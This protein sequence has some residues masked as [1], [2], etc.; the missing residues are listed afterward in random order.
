MAVYQRD[1]GEWRVDVWWNGEVVWTTHAPTKTEGQ[2]IHDQAKVD[3]RAG[4]DPWLR[5]EV[6]P[7]REA[8]TV[9]DWIETWREGRGLKPR[10]EANQKSLIDNHIV[11]SIG[12]EPLESL[13]R[14][15]V[16]R[17]VK[18]LEADLMPR[19][20][21]TVYSILAEALAD[22]ADDP[23]TKLKVSPAH[24]IR[25]PKPDPTG[26]DVLTP[27]QVAILIR[28]A[29]DRGFIIEDLAFTGMRAG[30]YTGRRRHDLTIRKTIEIAGRPDSRRVVARAAADGETAKRPVRGKRGRTKAPA[31]KTPAGARSIV[32]C[33]EHAAAWSARLVTHDVDALAVVQSSIMSVRRGRP[34][35]VAYWMVQEVV[36]EAR[37][38]AIEAGEDIPDGVTA[39]WFRVTHRTWLEEAHV[40]EI[41]IF[42]Q[43]GH[44]PKGVSAAYRRV[45]PAMREM[46]RVALNERWAAMQ[47]TAPTLRAVSE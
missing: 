38:A 12:K 26:R 39:H 17:W 19:S 34:I 27:T 3:L 16:Q 46:I 6:T 45:T 15:K 18:A 33:D 9:A 47:A 11:P 13:T 44:E 36:R 5:Y 23:A 4:I 8:T 35:A 40:P 2:A 32:L 14:L 37:K 30:E 28:Y 24:R 10:T 43:L 7:H 41:A 29:G 25:L 42:G 20:I 21:R 1:N 22:A 31:S